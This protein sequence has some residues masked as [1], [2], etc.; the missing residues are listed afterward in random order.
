LSLPVWIQF[1]AKALQNVP[2]MEMTVP[3]GVVNN[4]GEW[5]FEE[6][7]GG[8]GITTLGVEGT[9][10]ST[11]QVIPMPYDEEKKRIFDLFKN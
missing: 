4:G 6:Y 1:M 7:S 10:S 11:P 2:V 9:K 3:E 5:F 8:A